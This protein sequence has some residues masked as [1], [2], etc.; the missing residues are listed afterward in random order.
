MCVWRVRVTSLQGPIVTFNLLR[1]D[2]RHVGFAEVQKLAALNNITLRTGLHHAV[3]WRLFYQLAVA[4]VYV[5]HGRVPRLSWHHR[6]AT[7]RQYA[8]GL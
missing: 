3:R 4:R 8:P 1:R 5:Q 6:G 2:G 7:R